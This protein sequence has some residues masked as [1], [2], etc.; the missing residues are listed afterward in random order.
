MH[1]G[2]YAEGAPGLT[3]Y[4]NRYLQPWPGREHIFFTVFDTDEC[5]SICLRKQFNFMALVSDEFLLGPWHK[6]GF[7][8]NLDSS[9]RVG[10]MYLYLNTFI[11]KEISDQ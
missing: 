10:N 7:I 8:F 3:E 4:M 2:C 1:E 9:P 6:L 5:G 11:L